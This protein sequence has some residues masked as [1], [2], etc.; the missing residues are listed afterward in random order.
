MR[1][2]L[3]RLSALILTVTAL[4]TLTSCDEEFYNDYYLEG[5]WR[6]VEVSD[7]RATDYRPGD[8]L[9]YYGNGDFIAEGG[10]DLYQRGYWQLRGSTIYISFSH[11]DPEIKANI[12][13]IDDDY[14]ILDVTDY[15]YGTYYTLRL[16]RDRY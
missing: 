8:Y 3:S 1:K 5:T 15:E 9:T 13:S 7:Y 16:V 4:F 10:R 2:I 6:V 11:Y 12:R 14:L